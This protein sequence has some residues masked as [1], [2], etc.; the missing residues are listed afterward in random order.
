MSLM[1]LDF[2]GYA[3][4]ANNQEQFSLWS[5]DLKSP[6]KIKPVIRFSGIESFFHS[7][8]N[9]KIKEYQNQWLAITP[10]TESEIFRRWIFSFLSV[11]STYEANIRGYEKL[12]DWYLCFN[13]WS[14]LEEKL[15]ESRVGL[16]NARVKYIKEFSIKYWSNPEYFLKGGNENWCSYRNRLVK[17]ILGLGFAKVS[18]GIEMIYPNKAEIA[19]MDTHLYQ[20]YGL[21]QGK[22]HSLGPKIEE[23]FVLMSKMWNVP[24][25][26]ARAIFWDIK[27]KKEDSS[28]WT[29]VFNK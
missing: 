25:A 21:S 19:C 13:N 6:S 29:F 20:A 1:Q 11:H 22:H 14:L 5:E 16:H 4:K 7:I 10:N 9:S 23:H 12:K 8:S 17:E 3:N 28:Y 26:I 15:V 2:F 27:Q 24:A 18:F